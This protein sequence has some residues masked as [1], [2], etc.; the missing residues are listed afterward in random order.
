MLTVNSRTT[1]RPAATPGGTRRTPSPGYGI[2]NATHMRGRSGESQCDCKGAAR[3]R[4]GACARCFRRPGPNAHLP[5]RALRA[6][7][8]RIAAGFPD[9]NAE[10]EVEASIILGTCRGFLGV[11]DRAQR[12]AHASRLVQVELV[13]LLA[14]ADRACVPP[15]HAPAPPVCGVC[16][17]CTRVQDVT[18]ELCCQTP[19][20]ALLGCGG[21]CPAPPSL[22]SL[23][24]ISGLTD[25][26]AAAALE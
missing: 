14:F 1:P 6:T 26:L 16:V 3:A 7:P 5:A 10:R 20:R 19:V 9:L 23:G 8:R 25:W 11:C 4:R 21:C 24:L 2:G 12:Y 13:S 15:S 18:Y 22:R 17:V